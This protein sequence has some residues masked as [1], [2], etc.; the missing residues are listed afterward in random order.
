MGIFSMTIVV[1]IVLIVVAVIAY[2]MTNQG[3]RAGAPASRRITPQEYQA[4][5]AT[6][7]HLL[8]DVRTAKEFGTGHID[9]AA[10]IAIQDLPKEMATLPKEKPIVLYCRSGARSHAAAQ[11]LVNAGFQ[12]VYD[13]GGIT[14]WRA[15]GLPVS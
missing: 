5:Y 15:Q 3:S 1:A 2:F 10:N 4:N 12:D 6:R 14:Q 11:M 9:G 7:D 8:L 13:L